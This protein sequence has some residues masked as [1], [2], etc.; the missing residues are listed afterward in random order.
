MSDEDK[1]L[2]K[3]ACEAMDLYNIILAAGHN[4]AEDYGVVAK[5]KL[6]ALRAELGEP[7]YFANRNGKTAIINAHKIL[8]LHG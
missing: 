8:Y 3:E 7:V 5:R 2:A 6:N 1:L 4:D